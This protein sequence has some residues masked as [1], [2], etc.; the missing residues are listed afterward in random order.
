MRE[1]SVLDG[2][3]DHGYAGSLR[4]F[5]RFG[6]RMNSSRRSR[7]FV[8]INLAGTLTKFCG[9]RVRE[10]LSLLLLLSRDRE[11]ERERDLDGDLVRDLVCP[12]A[13]FAL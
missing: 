3:L 8:L 1:R 13:E 6:S 12:R 5:R 2:L 4:W 10:R 9:D 7:Y 11:A